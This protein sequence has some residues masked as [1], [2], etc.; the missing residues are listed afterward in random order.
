[1]LEELPPLPL[2]QDGVE[3][4]EFVDGEDEEPCKATEY[5]DKC[6]KA[7]IKVFDDDGQVLVFPML[8]RKFI[9]KRGYLKSIRS[10]S[11]IIS[12]LVDA[13][14][15]SRQFFPFLLVLKRMVTVQM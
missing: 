13:E 15:M 10:I 9:D 4:D 8:V 1:V 2:R 5:F 14:L 12:E 6:A 3:D 7:V 11:G